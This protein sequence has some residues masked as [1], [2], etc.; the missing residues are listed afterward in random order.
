MR[1]Q[2]YRFSPRASRTARGSSPWRVRSR[3]AGNA[4]P[5]TLPQ[6]KHRTG[7]IMGSP[8]G[9]L[10]LLSCAAAEGLLRQLAPRV[11]HDQRPVVF[12]EQGLELVVVQELHEPAGN[13]GPD[14][15]RLTHHA[16]ALHVH[17]DVD[18]VDLLTR[19]L[20][21]LQDLQPSDLE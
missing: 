18:G 10:P 5:T 2:Q 14:G 12:A 8:V 6:V 3:N 7:M 13:R 17:A 11:G 19:E 21:R 4:L 20:E 9:L 16:S 1:R 15:V